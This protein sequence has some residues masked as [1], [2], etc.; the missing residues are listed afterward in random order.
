MKNQTETKVVCDLMS[1]IA[2]A[3][4]DDKAH[5]NLPQHADQVA[6]H[7]AVCKDLFGQEEANHFTDLMNKRMSDCRMKAEVEEI[8]KKW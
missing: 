7:Y 5:I 1:F 6:K 2:M 8:S 4:S 3:Y